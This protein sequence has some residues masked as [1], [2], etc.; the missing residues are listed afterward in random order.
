MATLR[1]RLSDNL[2]SLWRQLAFGDARP[3]DPGLLNG[4]SGSER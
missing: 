2:G 4:Y 1:S 3:G